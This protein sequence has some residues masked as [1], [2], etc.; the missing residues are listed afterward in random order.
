MTPTLRSAFVAY[1]AL[2][3]SSTASIAQTEVGGFITEDTTW[4]TSQSPYL[5]TNSIFVGENAHFSIEPGVEVQFTPGRG[6]AIGD[7]TFSAIGSEDSPIKF[8]AESET[9][10]WDNISF[11]EQATNAF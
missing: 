3:V 1:L 5:V 10:P 9:E 2:L 4:T 7:G 6:I 8:V 11:T